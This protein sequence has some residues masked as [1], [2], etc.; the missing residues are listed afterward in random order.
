VFAHLAGLCAVLEMR[1]APGQ[2]TV[3][4]R[5]VLQRREDFPVLE[6]EHGPGELTV[7]HLISASDLD[8]Y[9]QRARAW[10]RAVWN[11]WDQHHSLIRHAV[12]SAMP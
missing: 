12:I 1:M 9:D 11:A 5:R 3:V 10:G 7:L 6:R 8:D 2:A 4:L